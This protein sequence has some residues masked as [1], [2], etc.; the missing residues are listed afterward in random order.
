VRGSTSTIN[1]AIPLQG[2]SCVFCSVSGLI[3]KS[4]INKILVVTVLIILLI[5]FY[6]LYNSNPSTKI[7]ELDYSI[8]LDINHLPQES[9]LIKNQN[10]SQSTVT[11]NKKPQQKNTTLAWKLNADSQQQF[12]LPQGVSIYESVEL[13]SNDLFPQPGEQLILLLPQADSVTVNIE[14]SETHTNGD[15][16]WR[17]HLE[18]YANDYPVVTTYGNSSTFST[19]TTPQGSYTLEVISGRG[20]IYKNPSVT[21]LSTPGYDD[22]LDIH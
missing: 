1:S 22:G 17:G 13:E 7:S 6:F 9:K 2:R 12:P 5:G 10:K 11:D 14:S 20:W 21:E 4:A 3:M 8:A 16:S 15:Y 18:G 19:I